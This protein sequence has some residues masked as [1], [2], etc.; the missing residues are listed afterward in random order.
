VFEGNEATQYGTD[1]EPVALEAY[2]ACTLTSIGQVGFVPHPSI[3]WLG[4]S[5]D[6]LATDR[7]VEIK[8]PFSGKV[9]EV[10]PGHYMAQ[11]QGLMEVVRLPRCDLAVWTPGMMRVF[12]IERSPEYW[13]WMYPKLAEFWAY[14][15]ADVEPPRAKKDQFDFSAL[16][17]EVKDY[18]LV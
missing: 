4:G 17:T 8:C 5:P 14:V 6:A 15:Q 18:G 1:H 16:V 12:T 9:Y 10:V 11:C 13:A 2:R 7:V 3:D